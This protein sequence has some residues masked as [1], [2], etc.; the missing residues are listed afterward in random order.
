MQS[1]D[2]KDNLE[3]QSSGNLHLNVP[4]S[5]NLTL[6]VPRISAPSSPQ[7]SPLLP[8]SRSSSVHTHQQVYSQH[9]ISSRPSSQASSNSNSASPGNS[10]FDSM[11]PAD[12]EVR[13]IN[14]SAKDWA[15]GPHEGRS[16]SLSPYASPCVQ[17]PVPLKNCSSTTS[18]LGPGGKE[19]DLKKFY[20]VDTEGF[21]AKPSWANDPRRHSI[22]ICSTIDDEE[23][24]EL[25]AEEQRRP[26]LHGASVSPGHLSVPR[27]KKMSPPCIAIEPPL[28]AELSAPVASLTKISESSMLLRR[29]T[30]SCEI[31]MQRDSLDLLEPPPPPPPHAEPP[32][33]VERR[34]NEH[35]SIP[36]FSFD[37]SDLSSL[38]SMSDILSDSD[39]SNHSSF[40]TKLESI[41]STGLSKLDHNLQIQSNEGLEGSNP[42]L[43][44]VSR[45]PLRKRGLIR[46][47]STREEDVEDSAV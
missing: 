8:R 15:G 7:S 37:Q 44:S 3:R 19:K 35:L 6:S 26:S 17:L 18:L 33:K 32:P 2:S 36:Q 4:M 23:V 13:H 40:D 45:S 14:S 47:A 16:N 10:M 12:E 25:P 22:E 38:S 20:S 46:M 21:L 1:C 29:R 24:F 27:K 34:R 43:L 41:A 39:Q 31:S 28:E 11:D 30:P 5:G 42:T 9:S